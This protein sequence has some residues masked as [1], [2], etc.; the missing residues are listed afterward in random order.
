MP[1]LEAD[2]GDADRRDRREG[3][4]AQG[5]DHPGARRDQR[6]RDHAPI[7]AVF[8]ALAAVVRQL[9]VRRAQVLIEGV[10]AEVTDEFAREIGVQWQSTAVDAD[11][12]G[13]LG[14][15]VIGG[16]NFPG[17]GGTGGILGARDQSAASLGTGLNL[18][19]IGGTITLPGSDTPILDIGA[20]VRGAARRRPHQHPVEAERRSTLDHHEAQLKVGQEVPFLTGP[21]LQ[22][23][24]ERRRATADQSVPDD[25]AQGRGP[26]RSRSRRTST[27]ATACAWTSSRKCPR[28]RRTSPGA[29]DLITNK[30][31][32]TTA[33][34]VA[35]GAMLVLGGLISEE[36]RENVSKVPALGDIPVLG[37]L[38]R[39]R[40]TTRRPAQPRWCSCKP[41]ILRDARARGGGV[42][43]EVQLHPRRA[44][45]RRAGP[46]PAAGPR[47][48]ARAAAA[49]SRRRRT[50]CGARRRRSPSQ[51]EREAQA[52]PRTAR[53]E[54]LAT[55]RASR[56]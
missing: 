27:K 7:P 37:N 18:G 23:T 53:A 31:E 54:R 16:T 22:H 40:N 24:G 50:L 5:R 13:T 8:R 14:Q 47:R 51:R 46:I 34:L 42:E 55:A 49:R 39:Y 48:N 10:I 29:S 3:R 36:V 28:S 17:A 32:I 35:D 52:L 33:V 56:R 1:I 26:Q 30:R 15:G 38:F 19:Y 12:D 11:A 20:L 44:A 43:R 4:E 41:T 25:R 45:A 9:D 21:V 2:R 6:A